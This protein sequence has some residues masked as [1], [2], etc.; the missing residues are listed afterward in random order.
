MGPDH[1]VIE[2]LRSNL[3]HR[4]DWVRRQTLSS[5]A[6]IIGQGDP[7]TIAAIANRMSD[8]CHTVRLQAVAALTQI[9]D[10]GDPNSLDLTQILNKDDEHPHVKSALAK[11]HAHALNRQ[12]GG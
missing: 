11:A 3:H 10:R 5:L 2:K 6:L 1:F 4:S 7:K 12:I 8:R 9:A